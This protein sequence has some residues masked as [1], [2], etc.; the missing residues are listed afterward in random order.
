MIA[1]SLRSCVVPPETIQLLA[2]P[3]AA[4]LA[5]RPL[6]SF[7]RLRSVRVVSS[8]HDGEPPESVACTSRH[9][10]WPLRCYPLT[11]VGLTVSGTAVLFC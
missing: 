6:L 11:P 1:A 8:V 2:L 3:S 5:S 9:A 4:L 7:Q 10:T